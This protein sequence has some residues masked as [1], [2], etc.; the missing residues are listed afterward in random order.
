MRDAT[1]GIGNKI[2][3]RPN[4]VFLKKTKNYKDF[5][6]KNLIYVV[7]LV[8]HG[9]NHHGAVVLVLLL[10]VSCGGKTIFKGAVLGNENSASQRPLVAGLLLSEQTTTKKTLSNLA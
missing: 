8:A 6:N 9:V 2:S 3:L 7:D 10:K 1:L 4:R 5:K